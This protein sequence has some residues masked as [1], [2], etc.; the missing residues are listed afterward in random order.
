MSAK[1]TLETAVIKARAVH[2]DTYEY[3]E[4]VRESKYVFLRIVC[5]VHGE[6]KQT[7]SNHVSGA[8]GCLLCGGKAQHTLETVKASTA[9]YM[10]NYEYLELVRGGNSPKLRMICKLH[11]E[12]QMDLYNHLAGKGCERCGELRLHTPWNQV[13]E[14]VQA[15]GETV[16]IVKEVERNNFGQRQMLLNCSKHGNWVTSLGGIRAGNGCRACS[17]EAKGLEARWR[18]EEFAKAAEQ[19]HGK[20]WG[21]KVIEFGKDRTYVTANCATHGEFTKPTDAHLRGQG[22]PVCANSVGAQSMLDWLV[23]Q[24]LEV[25]SEARIGDNN[26]RWDFLIKSKN[27]AVEYNGT[28]WHSTKYKAST[29]HRD[30]SR[31]SMLHGIRTIHVWEDEWLEKREIVEQVL[32]AACGLLLEKKQARSLVV[33]S[34]GSSVARTFLNTYHIQGYS[35]GSNYLGLF[36][37]ENLVAV[38]GYALRDTGRGR[39][40]DLGKCEITRY[41]SAVRVVGGFS[42]LL[43]AVLRSYPEIKIVATFSDSR[44]FSGS[45]YKA[46]G[47]TLTEELRPDYFYIHKGRRVH[48]T[49]LIKGRLPLPEGLE[50]SASESERAQALGY[51]RVYDS[52]KLR[53][54]YRP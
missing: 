2:G 22:C 40:Y 9:K 44:M 6:F 27:I 35:N 33:R 11:G 29:Y 21:Y 17:N 8:K 36:E 15:L 50:N 30:K 7:V 39:Q 20:Q 19:I 12:F 25:E 10:F 16:S 23:S 41:A 26:L 1:L 31:E 47:F 38:L 46:A 52:G 42:K 3:L 45:M 49:S 18:L 54:E 28:Y 24:G 48:K 14:S 5:P 43:K 4:L 37:G 32:K 13:L 53:W 34:V 51:F